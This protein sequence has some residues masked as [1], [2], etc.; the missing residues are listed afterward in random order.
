MWEAVGDAFQKLL[1]RAALFLV[2]VGTVVLFLG[3]AKG[4]AYNNWF[5][6]ADDVGRY[7]AIAAGVVLLGVGLVLFVKTPAP[8]LRASDYGI[9]ITRP[10]S[11]EPVGVVE[12]AGTMKKA[13]PKGYK[14][15][16]LRI[17]PDTKRRA[18]HPLREVDYADDGKSWN[19]KG[20]DIGG[21]PGENRAL[22]I[23]LVGEAGQALIDYYDEAAKVHKRSKK[24]DSE[25]LPLIVERTPDMIKC[26]EVPLVREK[27]LT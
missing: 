22:G 5:P 27:L 1:D 7:G 26:K 6:I 12:I 18:I 25:N 21:A 4:I 2:I 24:P 19:A 10:S 16:V 15:M 17:Y 20:C 23:Y 14:L 11:G 3:L 8:L 9:V 13:P